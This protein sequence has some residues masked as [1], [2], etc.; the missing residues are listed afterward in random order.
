MAC[1]ARARSEGNARTTM[2]DTTRSGAQLL[3]GPAG[4]MEVV[5]DAPVGPVRG[6]AIVGH[7]QP[8]LGGSALHKVPA[9][10]ARALSGAGW[11]VARPNFRGVGRSTGT[12]DEGIGE[13]EDVLALHRQLHAA[14]P[15]LRVALI[16]FSFGAFVMARAASALAMAGT[17]AAHVC[18]AGMPFGEVEGGRRYDTPQGQIPEALVVHGELDERVPLASVLD[19]ARPQ[20]QPVVVVP[21]ADHFFT[22]KLHVLRALVLSHLAG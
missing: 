6:L 9:F 12:H 17:P 15:E 19:W 7:P 11:W 21:A 4:P 5:F 8:L 20:V 13:T 22:G 18:L 16:G 1:G 2:I 14:H 10:L 3:E